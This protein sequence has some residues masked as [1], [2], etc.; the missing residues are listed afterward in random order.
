MIGCAA[1]VMLS[2]LLFAGCAQGTGSLTALLTNQPDAAEVQDSVQEPVN[3]MKQKGIYDSED[4]AVVVKKDA[5]S[6]TVQFQNIMSS[7][8][9]TLN[10]DGATTIYDKN[11]QALSMEQLKEGSVV[12][13]RFYKPNKSLAYVKENPDCISYNNVRGYDMDLRSGTITV[14]NTV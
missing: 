2:A 13:V 10:Y 5:E 12:T 7:R 4:A 11:D 9:Y 3:V 14:G 8:R 1:A 6:G